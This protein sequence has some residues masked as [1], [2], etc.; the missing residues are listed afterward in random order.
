[1]TLKDLGIDPQ[2]DYH[3]LNSYQVDALLAEADRV[4]YR[5]PK[6]ANGSRARYFHAYLQR[7]E[8]PKLSQKNQEFYLDAI[9][10]P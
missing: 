9:S 2:A 8:T 7:K 1:M 3:T 6:N 4:R 5:K 10:K